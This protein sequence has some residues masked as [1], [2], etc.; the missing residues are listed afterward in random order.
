[1]DG[2]NVL[3]SDMPASWIEQPS[4]APWSFLNGIHYRFLAE[5]WRSAA[6]WQES[7]VVAILPRAWIVKPG[8]RS[9][10][11]SASYL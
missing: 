10:R 8:R 4:D 11:E 9:R 2:R 3:F 7:T 1:V 5:K 6:E